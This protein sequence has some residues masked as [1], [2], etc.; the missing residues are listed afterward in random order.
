MTAN[1]AADQASGQFVE[2]FDDAPSQ[3]LAAS[4]DVVILDVLVHTHCDGR[5]PACHVI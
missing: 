4:E 5:R 2:L 1:E 3:L